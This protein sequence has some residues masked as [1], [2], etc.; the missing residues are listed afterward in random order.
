MSWEHRDFVVDRQ[1][2]CVGHF[3]MF[4]SSAANRL[5]SEVLKLYNHGEGPSR[6]FSWLKAPTR[7]F[8][9]KIH[10]HDAKWALTHGK[11]T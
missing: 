5:I 2:F 4:I 9:F 10:S 6:A 7:A 1:H 11:Y 3:Q 8:T